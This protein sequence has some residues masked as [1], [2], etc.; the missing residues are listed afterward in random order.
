MHSRITLFFER[1]N[2]FGPCSARIAG[3][4]RSGLLGRDSVNRWGMRSLRTTVA[5]WRPGNRNAL[6]LIAAV[7]AVVL[8]LVVASLD[9]NPGDHG[10]PSANQSGAQP[11]WA[12]DTGSPSPTPSSETYLI[13]GPETATGS[14][15]PAPTAA[16]PR[17]QNPSRQGRP[18]TFQAVAGSGCGQDATRGYQVVGRYTDGTLGWYDRPSGGWDRDGCS[19][20]FDALPMSG[21][22]TRDDA[23]AYVVWWFK[24]R[25]VRQG[26]CALAVYIPTGRE[27]QDVAGK[28]AFYN[29]VGGP[30]DL[31]RTAGFRIDQ[32]VNRGRWLDAGRF[33]LRDGRIGLQ[34]VTRGQ[35][36]DG[37][38]LAAAQVRADCRAG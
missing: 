4:I 30:D 16:A 10:T 20:Q 17:K 12:G 37:E 14:P 34:L 3:A 32:V 7:V 33:P 15:T 2:V 35:D 6:W 11:W 18:A 28:P 29:V 25:D 27:F 38:H 9:A 19:G 26:S 21:S 13:V 36:P 8:V 5:S 31:T 23:S 24:P 1:Y 22:A